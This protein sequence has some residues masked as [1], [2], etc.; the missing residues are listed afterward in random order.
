[1]TAA[2]SEDYGALQRVVDGLF[3]H[4]RVVSRL[5]VVTSAEAADLPRDLMEVVEL[6]PPGFYAR[7]RLCAQL[8]SSI[9]GHGWG[10]VYGT[11]K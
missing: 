5:D 2:R 7:E 1:M 6:L 10:Y 9:G 8:N 3:A 11:V 4:A